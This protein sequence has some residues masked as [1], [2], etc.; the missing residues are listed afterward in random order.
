MIVSAVDKRD[1]DAGASGDRT[2]N[3]IAEYEV[4]PNQIKR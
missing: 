3:L 4:H 1:S 2:A